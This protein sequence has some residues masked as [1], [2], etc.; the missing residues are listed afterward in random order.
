MDVATVAGTQLRT[1]LGRHRG[2]KHNKSG[3]EIDVRNQGSKQ[4]L[5]V[6]NLSPNASQMPSRCGTQ[7]VMENS[8]WDVAAETYRKNT[9]TRDPK[10][11]CGILRN[12]PTATPSVSR[13]SPAGD[14]CRVSSAASHLQLV[15]STTQQRQPRERTGQDTRITEGREAKRTR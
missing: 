10:Q 12:V 11:S 15:S 3:T 8:S 5:D 4:A 2:P 1:H 9:E 6:R 7:V 14:P 13:V